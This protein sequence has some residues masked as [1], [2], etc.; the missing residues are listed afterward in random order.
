MQR[1]LTFWDK[2]SCFFSQDH[3]FLFLCKTA[4][5]YWKR[6]HDATVS[7]ITYCNTIHELHIHATQT[8]HTHLPSTSTCT[9]HIMEFLSFLFFY[10][11]YF[12]DVVYWTLLPFGVCYF[13]LVSLSVCVCVCVCPCAKYLK[14]Y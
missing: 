10:F 5:I 4:M 3:V 6:I 1:S 9:I 2:P 13:A 14:N 11:S 12:L 7:Y 8:A